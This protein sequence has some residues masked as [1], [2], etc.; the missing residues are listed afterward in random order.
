[1]PR[2]RGGEGDSDAQTRGPSQSPLDT[3]GANMKTSTPRTSDRSHKTK[4]SNLNLDQD[5]T[6]DTL[7]TTTS[8]FDKGWNAFAQQKDE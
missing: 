8:H 4:T 3:V 6:V 7:R 1:M 5:K 2:K